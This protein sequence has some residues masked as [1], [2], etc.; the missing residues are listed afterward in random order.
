MVDFK[1]NLKK[2]RKVKNVTQNQL[3]SLIG[4]TRLT[5]A[6]YENG[7]INPPLKIIK[8]IADALNVSLDALISDK[9]R[10]MINFF[11]SVSLDSST[12]KEDKTRF[13][14]VEFASE[15]YLVNPLKITK[16]CLGEKSIRKRGKSK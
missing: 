3:A 16:L 12:E 4:K 6:R 13:I 1:E 7:E 11:K 8:R 9:D 14:K 2:I 5:I 10:E 15:Q